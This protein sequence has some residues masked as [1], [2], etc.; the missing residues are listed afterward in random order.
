MNP[1]YQAEKP[2]YKYLADIELGKKII[3]EA[4]AKNQQCFWHDI[5]REN[6][7]QIHPDLLI[8]ASRAMQ[9]DKQIRLRE[10]SYEHAMEY[11]LIK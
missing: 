6:N 11:I 2:K 3:K 1:N 8:E 9:R 5:V 10:C 4:I 7:G